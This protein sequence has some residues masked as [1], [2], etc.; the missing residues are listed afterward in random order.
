LL[1]GNTKP[2]LRARKTQGLILAFRGAVMRHDPSIY[3]L[4]NDKNNRLVYYIGVEY[5][6]IFTH[7]PTYYQGVIFNEAEKY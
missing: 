4:T 3:H 1:K 7:T 6:L 5:A 2:F